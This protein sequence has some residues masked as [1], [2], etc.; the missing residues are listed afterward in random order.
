MN[1]DLLNEKQKEAVLYTEG[2]L[3]ILAG[4]GSGKT[5]TLTYRMAHIV[6]SG[7]SP[8]QILAVTFTNKAA[9]EM[10]ERVESLIGDIPGAWLMT[11]HAMSLRILRS[12]A[13]LIG[14]SKDFTVYDTV[15][16]KTLM[17]AILKDLN[18]DT[19][20]YPPN[21][22]LSIISKNK[23]QDISVLEYEENVGFDQ[24]SK[25]IARV[26]KEYETR[27]KK[28]NAMDFDDLLLNCLHLLKKNP[29]VL[30]Y[31]QN[32]FR[33]IMVDEYQDTNAIQYE[34]VRLL[35]LGYG[36]ICAVGDD[37]QCIYEWRGADITNILGF[38][39]DFKNTKVIKLEQNYR[40]YQ[41]ILSCANSVIKNNKGRK[42]K[43]LW[44][45]KE[46]GDKILYMRLP[47][48]KEEASFV[49]RQIRMMSDTKSYD[50][51]AILYRTNAQSR[52]F[53]DSLRGLRIPYQVLSGFSFYDRKETKDMIS[54]LRLVV[55]PK[56]DVSFIRIINEP[57]KGIGQ[58]TL[59]KL[60]VLANIRGLS[61][62]EIVSD[63]EVRNGLSEK[64]SKELL[65]FTELISVCAKE[66][67]N[68]TISDI[69]DNLLVKSGYLKSLED[70]NTVESKSRIENLLDFKSFI[71]DFEK[72]K[73]EAGEEILLNE[74]LE[75]V[76]LSSDQDKYESE[77]GKVTLMTIHS[78]KGLEFPV[79]FVPGLEEGLFPS[80]MS[81]DT[82]EGMEEER[83]LCYVAFTRAMERLILTSA[84]FRVRFGSGDNMLESTFLK[85]IDPKLLDEKGSGVYQRS[86]R[87]TIDFDTGSLDG[88]S[89]AAFDPFK[90]MKKEV[91]EVLKSED[92][93]I[94][95]QVTHTKFGLGVVTDI[96]S[97]SGIIEIN[98]ES[99]G[100]KKLAI[101]V[102]PLKKV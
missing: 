20:N 21:F 33:Y 2:P 4:A 44:T 42:D 8:Y 48:D 71:Y 23:E 72:E 78:A 61:L 90:Y 22:F 5:K 32:K 15:D 11:F 66:I 52:L 64:V 41:N 60:S 3:L 65:N 99:V 81:R 54:Y 95:D 83:R 17:K 9:N 87:K 16:Q 29:D 97:N 73:R 13:D 40:S 43:K 59:S 94:G 67:E 19:K 55:N 100:I 69:Y 68:L 96:N 84:E 80:S 27:L 93:S 101:S 45:S 62:F 49:A 91:K 28:N 98:F 46:E 76:S 53:E 51:F 7:I 35:S 36:N 1:L 92:F 57:K 63:P 18:V 6:E 58:V 39:N 24:K 25:L 50:D 70:E 37:D 102:A 47:S 89:R 86:P 12:N 74:F 75:R 10:R 26:Y 34:I 30:T 88:F 31:Y 38:E 82:L 79:V 77:A 14:Y 85:E 56:D